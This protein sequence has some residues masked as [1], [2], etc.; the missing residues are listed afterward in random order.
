[1]QANPLQ[2]IMNP[3]SIVYLGGS[4]SLLTMGTAQLINIIKGGYKGKIY[5]IHRKK[6]QSWASKPILISHQLINQLT[7]R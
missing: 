6:K 1:M 2:T 7:L 3:E 5:P 4:N